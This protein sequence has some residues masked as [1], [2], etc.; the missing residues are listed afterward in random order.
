MLNQFLSEDTSGSN[1]I[2]TAIIK[3]RGKTLILLN[4]IY[5]IPNISSLNLINLSS[6]KQFPK[7]LVWLIVIGLIFLFVLP[8]NIKIFGIV[9]LAY[10]GWQFYQYQQNKLRIR[11]GLQITLNSGEKPIIVNNNSDSLKEIMLILYNIMNSDEA[12]SI[13]F[14]L[15]QSKII[16]DK[17][18]N[19]EQMYGSNFVAGN[20]AGDVVG[21][22]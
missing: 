22:V 20:V 19:V 18:I 9:C 14:N 21:N 8:G 2:S 16:E 7:Y 15:D 11:Y 17:S 3:I 12:R 13:T 10:S 1:E 6:T 5:Q 4:S